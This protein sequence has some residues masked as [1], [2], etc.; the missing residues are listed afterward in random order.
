MKNYWLDKGA[1][2]CLEEEI[3]SLL[4]ETPIIVHRLINYQLPET[5]PKIELVGVDAKGNEVWRRVDE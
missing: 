1:V 2:N 3:F 4:Q 5:P